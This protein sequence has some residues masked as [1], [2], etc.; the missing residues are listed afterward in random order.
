MKAIVMIV[1]YV[2]LVCFIVRI[3]AACTKDEREE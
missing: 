2:A 3:I 1:V